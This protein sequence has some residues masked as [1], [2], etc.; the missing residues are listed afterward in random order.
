[1]DKWTDEQIQKMKIG[2]NDRALAFF[3]KIPGFSVKNPIK[4][5]YSSD[6]ARQYRELLSKDAGVRCTI[7]NGNTTGT[8]VNGN[9]TGASAIANSTSNSSKCAAGSTYSNNT[10]TPIAALATSNTPKQSNITSHS[11]GKQIP[12]ASRNEVEDFFQSK[13][14]QNMQRPDNIPPSQG[15]KYEGF[16][17]QARPNSA[18]EARE[19][20]QPLKQVVMSS[21]TTGISSIS[22]FFAENTKKAYQTAESLSQK[23]NQSISGSDSDLYQSNTMSATPNESRMEISPKVHSHSQRP[24]VSKSVHHRKKPEEESWEAWD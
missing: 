13:I 17:N 20:A 18:Q 24:V 10:S 11:D 4:E 22:N 14:A 2:G 19:E 3:S 21:L 1:M 5:K 12:A 16:G 9:G 8:I 15:G 6:A 23:W 7:A